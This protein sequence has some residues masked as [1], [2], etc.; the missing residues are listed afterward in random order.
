MES[1]WDECVS[2]Y[3]SLLPERLLERPSTRLGVN[4]GTFNGTLQKAWMRLGFRMYG[5]E[6]NDVM[7]ELHAYGCEGELGNFFALASLP[8]A[9]FDF[10]V[11]DRAL[12]NKPDQAFVR[13]AGGRYEE[14]RA[15]QPASRQVWGSDGRPG[16]AAPP[17]FAEALRVLKPDGVLLAVLYR[18][19]SEEALRELYAAGEVT[20]T[21]FRN[22]PYLGVVVDR[23]K[24]PQPFPDVKQLVRS[25]SGASAEDA[26][27]RAR[28]SRLVGKALAWRG[29]TVM[30]HFLPTNHTV[31][32]HPRDA[33]ILRDEIAL[34]DPEA[35]AFFQDAT[36]ALRD[37]APGAKG[38]PGA[39]VV[40]LCDRSVISDGRLVAPLRKRHAAVYYHPNITLG[41]N[42]L[43]A[44]SPFVAMELAHNPPLLSA[45]IVIGVTD[46]D[47]LAN[48][49]S[50]K[51]AISVTAARR[52]LH[53]A[54]V[55]LKPAA[56]RITLLLPG[57]IEIPTGDAR[58]RAQKTAI[59]EHRSMLVELAAELEVDT[60]DWCRPQA[61]TDVAQ[62]KR[63]A[64]R[65]VRNGLLVAALENAAR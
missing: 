33:S 44:V 41:S 23:S 5:I 42:S 6:H 10:A 59:D 21:R 15:S 63:L 14:R 16:G 18:H 27:R 8:E 2:R 4:L 19:W 3:A 20:L 35:P 37:V 34:N 17:Y 43:L 65:N 64:K 55:R 40:F 12:F 62:L 47:A 25:L 46:R 49:R 29:G 50:G 51:T 53:Q 57:R 39:P 28:E 22:R 11:I 31:V 45:W 52:N 58:L 48:V 60:L 38:G 24:K 54:V 9:R 32:F 30:I 36:H 1:Y 7:E 61:V 13:E 56:A 26:V